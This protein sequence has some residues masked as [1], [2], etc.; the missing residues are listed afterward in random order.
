MSFTPPNRT[1]AR[2][3]VTARLNDATTPDRYPVP[4]IQD[5]S[6]SLA[7]WVILSKVDLIRGYH[8]VPVH[9]LNTP[10]TVVITPLDFYLSSC[11][12]RLASKTRLRP[13]SA[14]WTQ[15]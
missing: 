15:C 1:E 7:G 2:R 4:N 14:S 5:F 11:E 8:Q 9:P 12:C 6:A 13:S 3:Q 10:K